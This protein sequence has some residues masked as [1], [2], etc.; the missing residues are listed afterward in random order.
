MPI[1]EKRVKGE[2]I[3][4]N[5]ALQGGK[6]LDTIILQQNFKAVKFPEP[7]YENPLKPGA[8]IPEVIPE[9]ETEK[10]ARN[11]HQSTPTNI[12]IKNKPIGKQVKPPEQGKSQL[13]P[14]N[15]ADRPKGRPPIQQAN[16]PP[17]NKHQVQKHI[18][19]R[20]S[21]SNQ[22][23]M[24]SLITKNRSG[25]PPASARG[26]YKL[27][28]NKIQQVPNLPKQKVQRRVASVDGGRRQD[29][30]KNPVKAVEAEIN[31]I[32]GLKDGKK[33][34]IPDLKK[35]PMQK[36]KTPQNAEKR[37]SAANKGHNVHPSCWG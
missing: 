22:R 11:S 13:P 25:K 18:D 33:K 7:N 4:P 20:R 10:N 21:E 1:I 35:P 28:A 5:Q 17:Y 23:P 30:K 6:M 37:P 19:R 36:M 2:V 31:I 32:K 27:P 15:P 29:N 24:Y 8:P 12:A 34:P 3:P 16:R 9:E 14:K 26:I